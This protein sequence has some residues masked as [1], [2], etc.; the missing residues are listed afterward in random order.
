MEKEQSNPIKIA[1]K[2]EIDGIAF[3]RKAADKTKNPL[4]KKMFLSFIEDEK[5]H[6]KAL[7]MI[8]KGVNFDLVGDIF[9]G[10]NPKERI[11]TVF[12][13]AEEDKTLERQEADADELMAIEMAMELEK[14]G[15][16]YY[17]EISENS[18]NEEIKKLF[19]ILANEENQHYT[20][21]Q[22]SHTFLSD[23]GN[24]FIWEERAMI[25]G[26]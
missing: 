12:S 10:S 18:E 13:Q 23:T 8:V 22:N 20:I 3:Y 25:D 16:D 21:L 11:K 6:L 19:K 26:G 14:K 1:I 7:D 4:G 15:Y 17:V 24:W 2:M 5:N 9:K